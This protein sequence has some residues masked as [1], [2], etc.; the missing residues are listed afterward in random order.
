MRS[1]LLAALLILGLTKA[2][3]EGVVKQV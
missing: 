3:A 2:R 1:I